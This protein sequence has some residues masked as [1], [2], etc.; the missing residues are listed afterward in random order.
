MVPDAARIL[1]DGLKVPLH[2]ARGY[3]VSTRAASLSPTK[4]H[5]QNQFSA[6]PS[7][8]DLTLGAVEMGAFI[9]AIL[10]GMVTIQV[11]L[12]AMGC[13]SDRAWMKALVAF[14]WSVICLG[15]WFVVIALTSS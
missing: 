1:M 5:Q 2:Q 7:T 15:A 12:Y 11:Y 9:S 14:V 10:Y 4:P 13:K 3:R 8:L 6:M